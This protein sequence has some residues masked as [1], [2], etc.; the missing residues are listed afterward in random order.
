MLPVLIMFRLV[1]L[2]LAKRKSLHF[3]LCYVRSPGTVVPA[4]LCFTG[5]VFV[6]LFLEFCNLRH[7]ISELFWPIVMKLSYR[8]TITSI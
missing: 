3:M 1:Y 7:Y 8:P 2:S 4:V 5:D 6:V